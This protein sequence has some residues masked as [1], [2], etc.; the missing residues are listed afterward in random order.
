MDV[1]DITLPAIE[2]VSLSRA[3][4]FLRVEH[5]AEDELISD[6]IRSARMRVETYLDTSLIKRLKRLSCDRVS[7]EIK[8][9]HYPIQN[10]QAIRFVWS[11]GQEQTISP[12]QYR[13]NLRRKP[14]GIAIESDVLQLF[15]HDVSY[16][17]EIDVIAGYGASETDV[18]TPLVQAIL[19]LLAQAYERNNEAS[20]EL[21]MM[22]Q[23]LLM[24]YR[25]LRL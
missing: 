22:V 20:S 2:P 10:V 21:P 17:L 25:G 1:V 9:N 16:H 3:K 14:A 12:Q 19:I 7:D 4:L 11:D 8:I 24:P 5:D 6:M 13:V 15:T 18:P 23:A